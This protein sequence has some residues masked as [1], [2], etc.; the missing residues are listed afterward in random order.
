MERTRWKA[1]GL[2]AGGGAPMATP[3]LMGRGL[4]LLQEQATPQTPTLPAIAP[5]PLPFDPTELKGI[6]EQPLS[7]SEAK[8]MRSSCCSRGGAQGGR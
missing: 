1:L 3:V 5:K 8:P 2:L 7:S 4:A 6:S